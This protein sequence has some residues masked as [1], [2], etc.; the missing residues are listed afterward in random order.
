MRKTVSVTLVLL[1]ILLAFVWSASLTSAATTYTNILKAH[2]MDASGDNMPTTAFVNFTNTI[3]STVHGPITLNATGWATLTG[4]GNG[5]QYTID[6]YYRGWHVNQTSKTTSNTAGATTTIDVKCYRLEVNLE[7]TGFDVF[8]DNLNSPTF[9]WDDTVKYIKVKGTASS[10]TTI[11]INAYIGTETVRDIYCHAGSLISWSQSGSFATVTV[12]AMS[13][14]DVSIDLSTAVVVT[15]TPTPTPTPTEAPPPQLWVIE[16]PG[17][18][19]ITM[20]QV[21]IVVVIVAVVAVYY[22][23]KRR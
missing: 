16:V 9:Q 19:P 2:A 1:I 8:A 10:G 12:K 20:P 17:L 7:G 23:R 15:P 22:A 4:A 3:N 21:A 13:S 5:T 14:I 11:P 6:T 18:P